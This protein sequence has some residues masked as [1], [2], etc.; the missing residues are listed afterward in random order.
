MNNSAPLG[1]LLADDSA[2]QRALED[3]PDFHRR[4]SDPDLISDRDLNLLQI[5][6]DTEPDKPGGQIVFDTADYATDEEA[7]KAMEAL[8]LTEREEDDEISL[9]RYRALVTY[10][11]ITFTA[12]VPGGRVG[13]RG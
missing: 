12:D 13:D 1:T 9:G 4:F 10:G 8:F 7:M 2:L 11:E 6:I 3:R 5:G